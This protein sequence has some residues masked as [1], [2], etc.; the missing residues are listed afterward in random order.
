M[1]D[2]N[3]QSE[4][5]KKY[6]DKLNNE[7]DDIIIKLNNIK[8]NMEI[9]YKISNNIINDI[10]NVNYYKLK[11]I[12]EFINYNN[13]IINDMKEI[14]ENKN[15][16]EKL[17]NLIAI[18]NKM[19]SNY[20]IAEIYIKHEDINENIQIINSF[21]N[22]KRENKWKDGKED[23]KYENEKEIKEN[24][25][26]EIN[27]KLI[28][29]SYYYTFEKEGKYIIKYSFTNNLSKTNYMFWGCKSLRNINL[30]NFNSQFV[31][32]MSYMFSGCKSLTNI[33]L[34][35]FNTQNVTNMSGMFYRCE[36]LKNI[37]LSNFNTQNV[38][39]MNYMFIGCKSIRKENVITNDKKILNE[40]K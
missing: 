7:I 19:N 24:C 38:T 20:I 17:K 6:I 40:I 11:N 18:Y 1:P 27:D 22:A 26:I 2:N 37:N 9:Y 32:N 33:N 25:K 28:P 10:E 36:S 15:M 31:T 4:E 21:E 12:N 29:F 14:I 34:S 8:K 39:N 13:I 16:D 30:S 5:F 35:N 3:K 23:Y